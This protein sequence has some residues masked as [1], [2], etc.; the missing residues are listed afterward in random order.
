MRF[1][2][3]TNV[4]VSAVLLPFSIPR[5]ALDRGLDC[6][7]VA[8]SFPVLLELYEVLSRKQFRKYVTLEDTRRFLAALVRE[9]DWV[10]VN[11]TVTACRDPKDNKFLELALSGRASHVISGDRDLLA[12]KVFQ[13]I[14]ILTPQAFLELPLV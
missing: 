13:G 12:L 9:A 4:F 3:D 8:L 11:V 6:G 7:R 5:R 10:E 2:F 14:T 1:V